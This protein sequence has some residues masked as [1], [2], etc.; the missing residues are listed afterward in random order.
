MKNKMTKSQKLTKKKEKAIN[1]CKKLTKS[2]NQ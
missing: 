2:T 1:L